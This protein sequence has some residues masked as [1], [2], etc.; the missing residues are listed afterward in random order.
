MFTA[1][2]IVKPKR[3]EFDKKNKSEYYGKLSAGPFERGYGVTIGNSLRRMLL[4]S[5]EG[6]AIV[7]VKFEGIF[8]EFSSI[9]GVVED[10]TEIILN[11]KQVNLEL[12]GEEAYKR[13]YI[14]ASKPGTICAKD[15]TADPDVVVLNPDLPILTIDQN[16]EVE[17]EMI[18]QKG[19]G[20]VPADKHNI[21]NESVQMIP[22]DSS[23]SPIEK[24]TFHVEDTRVGQSTDYD[25]LVMELWTNGGITPEDA[26]AHAAKIVKDHMQIFINFDEEPEPVQPQVDE[27]KQKVLANMAKCV[28]ELELSVRSYNCLKNANIQTIAELVQKTDGEM[29]K[30]RNFGRKS[31]NEIKEILEDMGLHLGMKVD[32]EDLKQII[33]A[34]KK[35]EIDTEV[36]L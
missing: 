18:V 6:A 13:I 1:Q 11:L 27:K 10:V 34:Q 17:I 3:L 20:Y 2:G 32:E 8:H 26:V 7:A 9:P 36:E 16:G 28:E 4:S 21:E 25:S 5:I 30:T 29:L 33:Q 23:F 24:I 12:K 15:I 35:K 19:R 14:K 31:L 22:M